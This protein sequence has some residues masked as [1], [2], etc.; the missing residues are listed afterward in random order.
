MTH[1]KNQI[2]NVLKILATCA[3]VIN[4]LLYPVFS[5]ADFFLGK[6][7]WVATFF[8]S[9]SVIAVP[10]FVIIN[11]YLLL[12]KKETITR[13]Y[14]RILNRLV[15]PLI[16]WFAFFLFWR[17]HYYPDGHSLS[18]IIGILLSGGIYHYYFLV[19]LVGL[20]LLLPIWRLIIAYGKNYL[21]HLVGAGS[22]FVSLSTYLILYSGLVNGAGFTLVSWWLPFTGYFWWGYWRQKFVLAPTKYWLLSASSMFFLIIFLSHLGIKA[23]TQNISL[24]RQNGIFYWHSLVSLPVFILSISIFEATM[25]SQLLKRILQNKSILRLTN[26]LVKQTYGVYL[27]HFF[28]I[29]WIDIKYGFAI[30]FMQSDIRSFIITRTVLVFII[31]FGISFILNKTPFL[32]RVVGVTPGEKKHKS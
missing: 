12:P 26:N 4:H 3:V 7:W 8:Y 5:R 22:F 14:L 9:S 29:E 2:V 24:L 13:T 11:G 27:C 17:N 20:Q 30:E 21:I 25:N 16:F 10:L 28:V 18:Q 1:T 6:G 15:I 23:A 32:Q 19:L 31:S